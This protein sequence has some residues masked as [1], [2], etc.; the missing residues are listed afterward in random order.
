MATKLISKYRETR[1]W[2]LAEKLAHH[3]MPE[4]NSGCWLWT[5]ALDSSGY[6]HMKWL[7]RTVKAHRLTWESANGPIPSGMHIC[8]RCDVPSYV[9][10]EHLWL[11]TNQ[12]NVSDKMSKGRHF[13]VHGEVHWQSKLTP[14]LVREIRLAQGRHADIAVRFGM[15]Q[16]Q[17]S[18]I[19][20]G[21]AWVHV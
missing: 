9:N 14:E 5:G 11:G 13:V 19:K 1:H 18:K 15:S 3:S 20:R 2:T 16:P 6:G 7:G 8:H 12:D 10:L 4:P 21:E 17:V